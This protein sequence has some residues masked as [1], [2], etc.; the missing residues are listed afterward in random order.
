MRLSD[1]FNAKAVAAN[2]TEAASNS[3]PYLGEGFFPRDKKVGLDL[4]WIKG[5]KGLP[6]SLM[7]AAFDSKSTI[8]S[9]EGIAIQETEMAFFRESMLVKEKDEQEILRVQ[10][11]NDPYAIEVLKHIFDDT[12]TLVDGAN[13]VP[14]RMRMQL[15]APLGGN[16][17]INITASK[18]GNVANY[19]YNYD[20]TGEW[21][22]K[23]YLK[24][25][26]DTD[27]WSNSETCDP[28]A[29]LEKAQ[30][31][32]EEETG[33]RPK[34]FLMSKPTFNLIKASKKV[35][36]G[37]LA[38]NTTANVNYTTKRV[39]EYIEEELD[40]KVVIYSKSYKDEAGKAAKFYPDNIVMMLPEGTLGTTY[41]GTTPEERTL[42]SRS[43]ADVSIVDTGIAVSI[44]ITDDPVNTKTTVS[45]I[46]LPSFER[47]DEC[48]ALE[49]A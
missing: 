1:V 12:N 49:V 15:L 6:V 21:K 22:E 30:D 7:P 26:S 5:H 40:A 47:Q 20:P 24:I 23:H 32:Q 34:I 39:K 13:V 27:K 25:E 43:D 35:Q 8:R 9:R 33:N 48:Y 41:Y 4:K 11:S 42:A 3:I 28:V 18:D 16:I 10:D 2:Y 38:Q 14:E 31:N 36:S 37:I 19:A 44:T 46:L 29:D 45:E 17:G